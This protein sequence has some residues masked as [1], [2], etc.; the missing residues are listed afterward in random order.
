MKA[1]AGLI[2][3][4]SVVLAGCAGPNPNIGERTTDIAWTSGRYSDAFKTVK[5]HAEGWRTLGTTK[6]GNVLCKR[7]GCSKQYASSCR[8]V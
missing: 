4:I 3:L 5:P 6:A 2:F 1:H 7:Y 8:V